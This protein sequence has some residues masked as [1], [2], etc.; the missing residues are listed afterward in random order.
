MALEA[1]LTGNRKLVYQAICFVPLTSAVL[2]LK[3]LRAMVDE[4]FA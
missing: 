4:M 3:E 2:C 1:C